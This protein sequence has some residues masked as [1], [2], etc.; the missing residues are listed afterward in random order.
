MSKE[1]V[2][3]IVALRL[4]P[5]RLD[6]S[7][8]VVLPDDAQSAETHSEGGGTIRRHIDSIVTYYQHLVT[9]Q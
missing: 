2:A 8:A 1:G 5:V 9:T 6:I 3:P 4:P 7:E